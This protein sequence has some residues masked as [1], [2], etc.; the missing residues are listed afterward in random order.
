MSWLLERLFR[1][2]PIGW[3][4]LVDR[5]GRFAAA[6][7]GVGFACLLVF[8]QIGFLLA[9]G[10][11]VTLP[12]RSINADIILSGPDSRGLAGGRTI[13]LQR[14]YDALSVPGVIAAAPLYIGTLA[15][16]VPG[17][18]KLS[19]RVLG[20]RPGDLSAFFAPDMAARGEALE[21]TDTVMIDEGTRM[22]SPALRARLDSPTPFTFEANRRTL[23]VVGRFRIGAGFEADGYMLASDQ[24]FL[25]LFAERDAAAPTHVLVKVANEHAAASVMTALR[26]L[27]P[28]SEIVVR[29]KEEAAADERLF[30][31][32]ERP[33]GVI[34]GFGAVMGVIIG[35]V[36]VYQVL[37]TEVNDHIR[38]YA[39]LKAMGYRNGFFAGIVLEQALILSIAGF[40]PGA[41]VSALI[42]RLLGGATGLP[43]MM[44]L[45][46]AAAV[47]IGAV[48]AC[49]F[50]GLLATRRLSAADPAEL[51]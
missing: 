41:L 27:T 16:E 38:E 40:I 18:R 44:T 15:V 14:V 42:Y 11:S 24:T 31:T 32:V 21:L 9:L 8:F 10:T 37:S 12:Y 6:L 30:Q 47:F 26:D 51:Y 49:V 39:T 50:S 28:A 7:A 3:L 45:P 5:K 20:V 1:R 2:L 36:I 35:I 25:R 22:L 43:L 29:S 33:T 4:Q 34:F 17:E 13:P 46:L 23:G 19:M 48:A